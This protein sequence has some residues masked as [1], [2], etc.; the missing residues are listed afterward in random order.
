MINEEMQ[1]STSAAVGCSPVSAH[2]HR[3]AAVPTPCLAPP[4]P[5]ALWAPR[6]CHTLPPADPNRL[7]QWHMRVRLVE[8]HDE[9]LHGTTVHEKCSRKGLVWLGLLGVQG[10][11]R[12][13]SCDCDAIA[14]RQQVTNDERLLTKAIQARWK[15]GGGRGCQTCRRLAGRLGITVTLVWAPTRQEL[16]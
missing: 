4:P 14:C 8:G 5:P 13:L 9:G 2:C 1:R 11:H 15:P 12:R 3:A 10:K 7:Q 16:W 6:S